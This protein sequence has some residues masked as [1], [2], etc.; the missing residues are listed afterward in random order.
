MGSCQIEFFEFEGARYFSAHLP[1]TKGEGRQEIVLDIEKTDVVR[2]GDAGYEIRTRRNTY[3]LEFDEHDQQVMASLT[4]YLWHWLPFRRFRGNISK[5]G[6]ATIHDELRP[7]ARDIS[8][9]N[10]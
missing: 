5:N 7:F 3:K 8:T 2:L 6:I 9:L 1:V 4:K 10:T